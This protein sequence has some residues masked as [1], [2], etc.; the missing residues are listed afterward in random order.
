MPRTLKIVL[1]TL[2]A[3]LACAYVVLALVVF[4]DHKEKRVCKDFEICIKDSTQHGFI[5][6]ADIRQLL[7]LKNLLPENKAYSEINTQAIE[8]AALSAEVLREAQCYKTN[9]GTVH[10]L[11]VSANQ[12]FASLVLQAKRIIMSTATVIS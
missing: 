6:S 12:F 7:R 1:T 10:L 11:F 3:T 2:G 5:S 8:D 4:P 9:D